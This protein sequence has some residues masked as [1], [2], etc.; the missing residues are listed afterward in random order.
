MG[1]ISR[2]QWQTGRSY[3]QWQ[4]SVCLFFSPLSN[5]LATCI[6]TKQDANH[7]QH[8]KFTR[9]K[10]DS[11]CPYTKL[12]CTFCEK[13]F[14]GSSYIDTFY[15]QKKNLQKSQPISDRWI[16]AFQNIPFL[17]RLYRLFIFFMVG[18]L[19]FC[20]KKNTKI[21]RVFFLA[22]AWTNLLVHLQEPDASS[23]NNEGNPF[24][25]Y[26]IRF[27]LTPYYHSDGRTLHV[28]NES[29]KVSR[30]PDSVLS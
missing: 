29:E 4:F 25:G 7:P 21:T 15:P 18:L 26:L 3:R 24:P 1:Y 22:S 20:K 12:D 14:F 13:L 10:C 19:D 28:E 6:K 30:C 8:H 2:H 11:F 9:Y 5:A 17:T 16:W 23:R 27:N